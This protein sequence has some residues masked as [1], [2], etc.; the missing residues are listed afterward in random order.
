[1]SI[2]RRTVAIL[3]ATALLTLS[4]GAAWATVNDY[5]QRA[6]VPNGVSVAG[7]DLSG[8]TEAEARRA[9]DAAVLAPLMRTVTVR[10]DGQ[11]YVL[12]PKDFVSVDVDAMVQQAFSAR[13]DA[14][15][16]ARLRHDLGGY[17][18][19]AEVEPIYSVDSTVVAEW[20]EDTVAESVDRPAVDATR[21]REDHRIVITGSKAGRQT[22]RKATAAAIATIFES[23]GALS[24]AERTVSARVKTLKPE[25]TENSFSKSVIVDLSERRIRLFD[26]MELEITYPCAVGTAEFPTPTGEYEITL[27]RF[28]PTWVN[29]ATDGWGKDMPASIPSGPGNPLGTRALNISASGIRFHGTENIG[30]VG[31]AASHGCMRMVRSDIEDFFERVE[32]GTKVYIIP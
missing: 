8:M 6:Y 1:M 9:I 10:A 11:E 30:S 15:F 19:A 21:Y 12:D 29:P 14:S 13:R 31:T 23:V 3:L 24:D 16:I 28:L 2:V 26:G 5:A 4:A 17:E 20:L 27:K 18:L 22:D 7:S 32:V 25:V